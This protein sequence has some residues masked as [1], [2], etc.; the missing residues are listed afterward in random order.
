MTM[1]DNAKLQEQPKISL[2]NLVGKSC[3]THHILPIFS[4]TNRFSTSFQELIESFN[5]TKVYFK[6]RGGDEAKSFKSLYLTGLNILDKKCGGASFLTKKSLLVLSKSLFSKYPDSNSCSEIDDYPAIHKILTDWTQSITDSI[7]WSDSFSTQVSNA[8]NHPQDVPKRET[9]LNSYLEDFAVLSN[10]TD[11]LFYSTTMEATSA[12][13]PIIR[14]SEKIMFL[15][16]ID[17]TMAKAAYE[18]FKNNQ[19]GFTF[20]Y[21]DDNKLFLLIRIIKNIYL[22][23]YHLPKGWKQNQALVNDLS[24]RFQSDGNPHTYVLL[25]KQETSDNYTQEFLQLYFNLFS[26]ELDY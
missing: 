15:Q 26:N 20:L 12:F 16:N 17:E 18:L 2:K 21:D 7:V 25:F 22:T 23:I 5:G 6:R 24:S 13:S 8:I 9:Y 1:P 4:C 11:S 19:S 10:L 3:I 14:G